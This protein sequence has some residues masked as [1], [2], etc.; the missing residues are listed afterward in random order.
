MIE[1]CSARFSVGEA[2]AQGSVV[3]PVDGDLQV[4]EACVDQNGVMAAQVESAGHGVLADV[5]GSGGVE[6]GRQIL[7]GVAVS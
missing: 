2:E 6:E 3:P 4:G 7:S 5:Q 1:V